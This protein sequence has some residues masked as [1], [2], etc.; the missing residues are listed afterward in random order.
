M[1]NLKQRKVGIWHIDNATRR[2]LKFT[3]VNFREPPM[4]TLMNE[5][6]HC[7]QFFLKFKFCFKFKGNNC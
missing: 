7:E 4:R 3:N 6:A 2:H 5:I 1:T